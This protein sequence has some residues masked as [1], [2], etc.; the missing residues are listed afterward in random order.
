MTEN[1]GGRGREVVVPMRV[2]KAVTVFATLFAVVAVVGGFFLLDVATNQA[3]AP[4]SE[5]DPLVAVAGLG[6]IAAGGVV[7][8]FAS[9]FRARGMGK[10]KD[11]A[12]A[13]E[14]S[15]NG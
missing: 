6:S 15:D 3:Q 1:D 5:I 4:L 8:A 12:R 14:R 11:K 2:Y 9:R 10:G 7:Y 13:D